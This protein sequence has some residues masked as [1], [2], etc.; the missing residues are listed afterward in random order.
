MTAALYGARAGKR[1]LLLEAELCGGQ[2]LKSEKIENYPALPSVDGYTFAENLRTQIQTLGVTVESGRVD[3]VTRDGADFSVTAEGKTYSARTVIL[4]TGQQYR[5]LGVEGEADLIGRGVSFCA[6]C[7]GMFFRG[8]EVAVIGGGNTAVQDALLLSEL[9]KTVYLIHRRMELRAEGSL[10]ARMRAKENVVF[11]GDTVVTQMCGTGK[12]ESLVLQNV[13]TKETHTL[14]VSGAFV[15]IGQLP[16]NGAFAELVALDPDGYI[17]ADD[18]CATSCAGV[19]AAGDGRR[20]NV[21]QLTT[22]VSDG[23]VAAL[24]AVAYLDSLK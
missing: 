17:V 4:A 13:G 14:A 24:S 12:L 3:S 15:A 7:D 19:F 5:K 9:C 18:A 23:T 2:I 1:V 20:K 11:M 16:Q 22:A 10:A 21:R 8:R 6:T